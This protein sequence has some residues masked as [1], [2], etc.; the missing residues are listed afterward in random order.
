M[1]FHKEKTLDNY[2]LIR[3]NTSIHNFIEIKKSSFHFTSYER[4]IQKCDYNESI[5]MDLFAGNG[6]RMKEGTLVCD[7]L[8]LKKSF[9]LDF[10]SI[11][12][13]SNGIVVSE[14]LKDKIEENELTG[15][16]FEECSFIKIE[17]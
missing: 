2:L 4:G 8:I 14:R 11:W 5:L 13:I 6:T 16:P 15:V 17:N 3:I 10:F 7:E 1:I 9:D 12:N